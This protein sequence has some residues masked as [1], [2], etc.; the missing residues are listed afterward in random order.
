MLRN[1]VVHPAPASAQ[2]GIEGEEEGSLS[3]KRFRQLKA[4][5]FA[6]SPFPSEGN[7]FYP[8]KC[9]SYGCG[10]WVLRSC[11]RLADEFFERLG[12]DPAYS[13]MFP[14][15]DID[16]FDPAGIETPE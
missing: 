4:K 10:C 3:A 11:V 16:E 9:F 2:A 13:G 15:V 12:I 5:G 8:A 14:Q 6:L 1:D 7:P